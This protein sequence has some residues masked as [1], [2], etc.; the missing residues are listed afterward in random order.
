MTILYGVVVLVALQ[1]L[2]ELAVARRNTRR[3]MARGGVEYGARHYPLI[4]G[5]HAAWLASLVLLVPG[6]QPVSWPLIGVY[7]GLQGI[8]YWAIRS[9]GPNWTTRIVVVPGAAT[10]R[11]GPYRYMRHP[12]YA[13]VVCEIALLPLAFGAWEI[14]VVFSVV[15]AAMLAHR[16][17][18]ENAALD[19]AST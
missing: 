10:V 5:L 7:A 9:L 14:A 19:E 16:I 8:R 18:I 17:R 4:V 13:V 11:H 1:R 12:N 3:L 2:A 15:N 6:D